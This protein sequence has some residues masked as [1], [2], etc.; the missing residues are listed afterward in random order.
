M[1][2][3][4]N[5]TTR[6]P[7]R[8]LGVA[9]L[10]AV[11]VTGAVVPAAQAAPPAT[12]P[13]AVS[14]KVVV[15]FADGVDAA[16]VAREYG[17][18]G[19]GVGA[20]WKHALTGAAL[21]LP[22]GLAKKLAADPRVESVERD[23][24]VTLA[25][26]PWD[27]DRLDQAA[28]PLDGAYRPAA[29]GKG[30]DLYVL[31]TGVRGTH[32]EFSGRLK[33]GFDAVG[34]TTTDDCF[35]HGTK[36]ASAAAGATTGSA[37]GAFV[38][39]V[40][41]MKC[42]GSGAWSQVISG[43]NWVTAQHLPGVPAVVNMSL[44]GSLSS[45]FASAVRAAVADGIVVVVSAGNKST[46]ACTVSPAATPEAITVGATTSTDSL[47]SFSNRGPCV[48]VHAPGSVVRTASMSTDSAYTTASGTSFS[49][50]LTAG[51]AAVLLQIDPAAPPAVISGRL[52]DASVRKV[53]ATPVG[54][55][56]RLLQIPAATPALP[57]TSGSTTTTTT[58]TST[59]KGKPRR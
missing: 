50:P 23:G 44:S 16:A 33:P 18:K 56:D 57:S 48:D 12:S 34:G 46:D 15:V 38:I 28:L 52:F 6:G 55:T 36:V 11:A 53:T 54:T 8:T 35:G 47:A 1:R 27:L 20:V 19:A 30:V 31:D 58:P 17:A 10:A 40:R 13:A 9:A 4:L 14:G 49:A 2:V 29:T 43:L 32:L 26:A 21:D 42:D 7:R 59:G 45:S 51:A 24:E 5:S 3:A 39:P 37:P 41:A 22:P 25:A